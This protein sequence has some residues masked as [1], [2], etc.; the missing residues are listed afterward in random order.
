M[1]GRRPQK[2]KSVPIQNG[3]EDHDAFSQ[4]VMQASARVSPAVIGLQ[5][6][7]RQGP[8]GTVFDGAGSAVVISSDGYALTNFHVIEQAGAVMALYEDGHHGSVDVVGLD[9][10]TD[11]ALVKLHD[12]HP[13]HVALGDS[14]ALRVGQ[15]AIAIG[16]PLGLQSTVTVGVVSALRRSLR[17]AGGKM[18]EDVIQT[19][20]ALNPGNSGGALVDARGALVG[21]NT[22]IV[23]GAQGLCFA[24]PVNTAK[25]ILP[26]LM[27]KG[28]VQ[29]GWMAISAQT[30]GFSAD[31]ARRLGLK[32]PSGV[33]VVQVTPG[34]PA[35]DAKLEP[36]DVILFMDGEP[37]PSMD[38]VY[39]HIDHDKIGNEIRL[40]VLRR[41]KTVD[42]KMK[43]ARRPV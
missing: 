21:I 30:Q 20:A 22:A 12:R 11:L 42:L 9:P 29:R 35:D 23:G 3:S 7:A 31:L 34:G 17:G 16:N 38:A 33:L 8:N 4:T 14:S 24:V 18:I 40:T 1:F 37:V 13:G 32:V 28:K 5:R 27:R 10:D 41:G 39:K 6:V 15:L 19:D 36:G 43:V 26:D 25:A 2:P